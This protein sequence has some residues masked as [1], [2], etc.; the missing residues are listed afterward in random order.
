MALRYLILLHVNNIARFV[1]AI[2][3][4]FQILLYSNISMVK[5]HFIA[6]L[7]VFTP[8]ITN[9]NNAKSLGHNNLTTNI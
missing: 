4:P 6:Y 1:Y 5:S 7:R 2:K 8:T 3:P 9:K